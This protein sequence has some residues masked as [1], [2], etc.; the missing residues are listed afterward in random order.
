MGTT[1]TRRAAS[2]VFP[3][4]DT[5]PGRISRPGPP[6]DLSHSAVAQVIPPGS[7][8]ARNQREA[9]HAGLNCP[10]LTGTRADFRV[11]LTAWWRIHVYA[12]SWGGPGKPPRSTTQP[13]RDRVCIAAGR[14][15]RPMSITTYKT[16]RAWWERHGFVAIVRRGWTPDLSPGVLRSADSRNVRQAYVLCVPRS[17][18]LRQAREDPRELT[19]P[20][21][22][23]SRNLDRVHA[24]TYA[25]TCTP[26]VRVDLDRDRVSAR[27]RLEE[28]RKA[29]ETDIPGG[30][31]STF[32]NVHNQVRAKTGFNAN[33]YNCLPRPAEMSKGPLAALTDGWWRNLTKSFTA[34]GWSSED[35]IYAVNYLPGGQ[36]HRTRIADVRHPAGW[37]RWRLGHWLTPD[38]IPLPSR[39]Q[40]QAAACAATPGLDPVHAARSRF[41]AR[42]YGNESAVPAP[43]HTWTPPSAP[44]RRDRPLGGWAG[45]PVASQPATALP[46]GGEPG[47]WAAVVAQRVAAARE[48]ERLSGERESHQ[49]DCAYDFNALGNLGPIQIHGTSGN[50][51]G[52]AAGESPGGNFYIAEREDNHLFSSPPPA[53]ASGSRESPASGAGIEASARF[54]PRLRFPS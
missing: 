40:Q 14:N 8:R 3:S 7:R 2:R 26:R 49:G 19:R 35:L 43:Q 46:G 50:A 30:S 41:L 39:A 38:G 20:L 32:H 9:L 16:C 42:L 47:W 10:A 25:R 17:R 28:Q 15:G 36:Q 5:P 29:A 37:L 18:S 31:E 51:A 1:I 12:A 33:A 21:S 6:D 23:F 22:R 24:R 53:S 48:E 54:S 4:P 13:G 45:R 11:H 27:A 34:A 44:Q 52:N